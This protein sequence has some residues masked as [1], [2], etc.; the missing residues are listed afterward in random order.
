MQ[1]HA[2]DHERDAGD[3]DGR[4]NLAVYGRNLGNDAYYVATAAQPLGALVSAGGTAGAGG[5]F[6]WYG[7]PRTYGVELTVR[8]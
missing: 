2:A 4:W 7:P 3:L 8:Y 1:Q 6:G 5:F